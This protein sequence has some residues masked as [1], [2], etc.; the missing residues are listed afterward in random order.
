MAAYRITSPGEFIKKIMR[1]NEINLYQKDNSAIVLK[2]L[3][4]CKNQVCVN[5][6]D[7]HDV[8]I[9]IESSTSPLNGLIMGMQI[10]NIKVQ[11]VVRYSCDVKIVEN[12]SFDL[13]LFLDNLLTPV[14]LKP[15]DTM[16]IK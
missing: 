3:Y 7:K 1:T 9:T 11:I 16:S 12:I 10:A 15:Y 8:N 14:K 2:S 13:S 4:A 5:K 6:T